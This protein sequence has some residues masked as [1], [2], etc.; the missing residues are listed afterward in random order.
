LGEFFGVLRGSYDMFTSGL[1]KRPSAG[2]AGVSPARMKNDR[3]IDSKSA[4]GGTPGGQSL[5]SL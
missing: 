3:R 4:A 2:S 1:K 5:D